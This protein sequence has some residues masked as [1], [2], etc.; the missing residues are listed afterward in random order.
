MVKLP[1]DIPPPKFPR[2]YE[3]MIP[4]HL[5]DTLGGYDAWAALS[6]AL[7]DGWVQYYKESFSQKEGRDV[8]VFIT[9]KRLFTPEYMQDDI[10]QKVQSY[11]HR[12]SGGRFTALQHKMHEGYLLGTDFVSN[13]KVRYPDGSVIANGI[14]PD[15]HGRTQLEG[16]LRRHFAREKKLPPSVVATL[17]LETALQLYMQ[18]YGF[19]YLRD[20]FERKLGLH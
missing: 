10:S 16:E 15:E 1:P 5:L 4:R 17:D 6:W 12:A 8:G 13:M 7:H 18:T 11:L 20:Q 14:V 9:T 3:H 19:Y 2:P